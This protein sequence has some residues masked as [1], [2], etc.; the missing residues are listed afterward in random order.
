MFVYD[1]LN[2]KKIAQIHVKYV[3]FNRK[4]LSRD[5]GGDNNADEQINFLPT[6][7]LRFVHISC[8]F[9]GFLSVCERNNRY[10]N[11][12]HNGCRMYK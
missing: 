11:C 3:K 1:F 7:A 10:G 4:K 2:R 8:A 6:K 12:R 5:M 9:N